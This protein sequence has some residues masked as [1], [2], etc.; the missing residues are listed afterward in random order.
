M[1]A[2]LFALSA[3]GIALLRFFDVPLSPPPSTRL[4]NSSLRRNYTFDIYLVG[5]PGRTAPGVPGGPSD[6]GRTTPLWLR[7]FD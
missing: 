4:F 1:L 7:D 2:A 6:D 3:I 5:V